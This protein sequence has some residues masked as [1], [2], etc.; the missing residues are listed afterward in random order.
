M[1]E[2]HITSLI[3][4]STLFVGLQTGLAISQLGSLYQDSPKTEIAYNPLISRIVVFNF[5]VQ[6]W[7]HLFV[8]ARYNF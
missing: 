8:N 6:K 4:I 3:K 1:A 5:Y 7:F 2:L